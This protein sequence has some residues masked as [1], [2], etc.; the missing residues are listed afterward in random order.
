MIKEA[1][2]GQNSSEVASNAG[3]GQGDGIQRSEATHT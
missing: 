3:K 2:V 1:L